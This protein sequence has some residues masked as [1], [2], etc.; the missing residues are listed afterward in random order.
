MLA[1]ATYSIRH[2]EISIETYQITSTTNQVVLHTRTILGTT[3]T[4]MH[5]TVLLDVV[6]LT[7]DNSCNDLAG[8]QTNTSNLTL[9]GV[10]LLGLG[11]TSLQTNTLQRRVVLQ[12]W[13]SSAAR[14]L[15]LAAA[16]ADLV[17]GCADN[18][19]AGELAAG[20]ELS[21]L[22]AEDGLEVEAAGDWGCAVGETLDRS[23]GS[24]CECAQR[25]A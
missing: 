12:G 7:G 3:A 10:G 14:A 17:V 18:R 24:G 21:R 4:N 25:G 16:S 1:D 11:H 8:T 20:E 9:A 15:A 22:G 19:G 6:A 5:H 13:G 23:G 2:A